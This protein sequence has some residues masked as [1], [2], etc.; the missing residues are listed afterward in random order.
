MTKRSRR[1]KRGASSRAQFLYVMIN[2]PLI[3]AAKIGIT[4]N[5]SKRKRNISESVF[6]IAVPVAVFYIYDAH[7]F[8]QFLHKLLKPMNIPFH[9]S[10]KTEWFFVFALVIAVPL[11]ILR[12]LI[13]FTVV[14]LLLLVISLLI[15]KVGSSVFF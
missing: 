2:F 6:G 11:L 3:F 9:G 1:S 12:Q 14:V 13:D 4:G 15:A 8:E 10:G 7:G 5:V